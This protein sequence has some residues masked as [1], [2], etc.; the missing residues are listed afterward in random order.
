MIFS[1]ELLIILISNFSLHAFS[2]RDSEPASFRDKKQKIIVFFLS[3]R[4]SSRAR[5]RLID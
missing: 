1:D 3:I 5:A 4:L 2:D